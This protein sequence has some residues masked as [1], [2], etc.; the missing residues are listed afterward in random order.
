MNLEE[1]KSEEENEG[2]LFDYSAALG[3]NQ[4]SVNIL[5][6]KLAVWRSKH[7]ITRTAMT[8]LLHILVKHRPVEDFSELPL[9]TRTLT[10][11]T[12]VIN[13]E[14]FQTVSNCAGGTNIHLSLE[15]K[16]NHIFGEVNLLTKQKAGK[17]L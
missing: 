2:L 11:H 5:E 8:D 10:H 17:S 7:N 16:T 1:P 15:Y 6:G 3:S 13:V 12:S 4:S 9:E 14:G